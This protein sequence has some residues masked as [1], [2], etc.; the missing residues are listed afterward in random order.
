MRDKEDEEGRREG[1]ADEVSA[2]LTPSLSLSITL[3]V[4][5]GNTKEI[6]QIQRLKLQQTLMAFFFPSLGRIVGVDLLKKRGFFFTEI[7]IDQCREV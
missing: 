1:D 4:I 7:T 3:F 5:F 6:C 2:F